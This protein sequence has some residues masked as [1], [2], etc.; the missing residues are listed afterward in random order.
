MTQRAAGVTPKLVVATS[1]A[2][3]PPAGGGQARVAGLYGALARLG[4]E[5]E[6]VS[7]VGRTERS[8]WLDSRPGSASCACRGRPS[9]RPRTGELNQRVGVPVSDLGL[10]LHHELT[11]AYAAT[12]A[13]AAADADAVVASHPFAFPVLAALG[14]KPMIYEAHNVEADLKAAMYAG[15]PDGPGYAE[16]VREL[17]AAC[18]AAADNVLVCAGARRPS[19][20]RVVRARGGARGGGAQRRRPG[21]N[22]LHTGGAP[23]RARVANSGMQEQ[24]TAVFVGSWHEPNLVAIRDLLRVADELADA[25]V[26][27]LICGSGGPRVRRQVDPAQLRPLRRGRRRLP[28]QRPRDRGRGA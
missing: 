4:V 6:I 21:V 7:L 8:G 12:L 15:T 20:D 16:Q 13:G 26:R 11:P 2:V 1:F 28:A 23:A 14:G 5:V 17:E 19:A 9:T 18:C 24:P 10:A 27:V 3:H 22:R 25:R